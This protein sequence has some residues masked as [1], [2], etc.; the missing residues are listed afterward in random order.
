MLAHGILAR[1]I[2]FRELLIHHRDAWRLRGIGLQKS[3]ATQNRNGHRVEIPSSTVSM[4]EV[5]FSRS[6]GSCKPSGTKARPSK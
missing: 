2:V 4:V 1:P 5:K 3:A 6:R